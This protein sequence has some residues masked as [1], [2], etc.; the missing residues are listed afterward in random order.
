MGVGSVQLSSS[1]S[2]DC[3]LKCTTILA[4]FG[5][6][7]WWRNFVGF[8]SYRNF[9]YVSL[10]NKRIGHPK[11]LYN[12]YGMPQSKGISEDF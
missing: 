8:G 12:S 4:P 5:M 10:W 9:S 6:K 2:V 11:I 3:T 7:D 1:S